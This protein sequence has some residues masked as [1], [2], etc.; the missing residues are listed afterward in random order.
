MRKALAARDP[1]GADRF[2][3]VAQHELEADPVGTAERVYAAAGLDLEGAVADSM[4]RW[5]SENRR[6]SRGAHRY[7]LEDHGLSAAEV[8][9]VFAPYLERF[10]DL[11]TAGG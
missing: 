7:R 1:L 11:T 10:G 4:A 8:T 2:V 6:G 5:A 3:D 9:N